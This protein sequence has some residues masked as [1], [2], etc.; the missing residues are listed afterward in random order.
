MARFLHSLRSL[1]RTSR[2]CALLTL[3]PHLASQ[4]HLTSRLSHLTDATLT[5]Q[6]FQ[7]DAT[8]PL[9]F[10][11][12]HGLLSTPKSFALQSLAPPNGKLSTL[13]GGKGGRNNLAFK[14][15]R[16]AFVVETM[17]LDIDGGVGERRTKPAEKVGTEVSAAGGGAHGHGHGGHRHGHGHSHGEGQDEEAAALGGRVRIEA[18]PIQ[19]TDE[20]KP[21]A[22]APAQPRKSALKKKSVGFATIDPSKPELYEF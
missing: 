9:L 10:P 7:S 8:L 6:G 14:L 22:P 13:V 12:H 21:V 11:S 15:K 16:K 1:L 5:L 17:H 18:E 20:S 19:T 4:P 2:T 3:P